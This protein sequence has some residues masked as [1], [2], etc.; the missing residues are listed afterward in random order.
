MTAV[1]DPDQ[2]GKRSVGTR[3]HRQFDPGKKFGSNG[4][5]ELARNETPHVE[6][7][8]DDLIDVEQLEHLP[9]RDGLARRG[10]AEMESRADQS[11]EKLV[12]HRKHAVTVQDEVYVLRHSRLAIG[13]GRDPAG[14]V[15]SDL[16]VIEHGGQLR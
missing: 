7:E 4:S 9:R 8:L 11:C 5:V 6:I 12:F 16:K 3:G 13:D 2:L 14:Q 15:V 1:P 10:L